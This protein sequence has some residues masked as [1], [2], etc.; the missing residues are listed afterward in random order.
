MSFMS[1]TKNGLLDEILTARNEET[2]DFHKT[3]VSRFLLP[4]VGGVRRVR[5]LWIVN[6]RDVKKNICVMLFSQSDL[7]SRKK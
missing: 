7:T 3:N 1:P 5:G 2:R 4:V 6:C